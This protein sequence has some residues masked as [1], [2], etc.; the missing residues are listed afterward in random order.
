MIFQTLLFQIHKLFYQILIF[1]HSEYRDTRIPDLQYGEVSFNNIFVSILTIFQCLTL[2][3]WTAIMYHY[4]DSYGKYTTA[5]YFIALVAMCAILFM[6][7]IV[8]ILFDNYADDD[9]EDLLDEYKLMDEK[10]EELGIPDAISELVIHR[11]LVLGK[12]TL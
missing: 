4:Q 1:Y 8:A 2:E 10:A 7:V 5:I 9:D 3:G 11:D 12:I 6:N